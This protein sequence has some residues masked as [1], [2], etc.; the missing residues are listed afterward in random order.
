MK[1]KAEE[2]FK[3]Y[4]NMVLKLDK[5]DFRALKAGKIVDINKSKID[6]YPYLYKEVKDGNK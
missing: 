4:R 6:D 5:K 3:Y 2:D 1:V